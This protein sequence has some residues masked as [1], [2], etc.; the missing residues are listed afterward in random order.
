VQGQEAGGAA[1]T[2]AQGWILW[3]KNLTRGA[4]HG[5]H[6]LNEGNR[7]CGSVTAVDGR[8]M[9]GGRYRWI[10]DEG[11][12]DGSMQ[13]REASAAATHSWARAGE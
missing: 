1:V 8:C 5:C 4:G 9:V 13:G 7:R 2:Q 10:E 6:E 3:G 12:R 11:N